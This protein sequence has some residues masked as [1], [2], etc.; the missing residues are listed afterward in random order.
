MRRTRLEAREALG[1]SFRG[2]LAHDRTVYPGSLALQPLGIF[3]FPAHARL[4][5]VSVH[6]PAGDAR[7]FPR[8][9]FE[10]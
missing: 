4:R 6:D 9:H 3:E 1:R 5:L 8:R 10:F 7:L 2:L